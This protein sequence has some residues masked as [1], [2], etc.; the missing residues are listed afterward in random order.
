[1]IETERKSR[2]VIWD[3][4]ILGGIHEWWRNTTITL[5][6]IRFMVKAAWSAPDPVR[7]VHL[8]DYQTKNPLEPHVVSKKLYLTIQKTPRH[9]QSRI[10]LSTGHC[11]LSELRRIVRPALDD[12]ELSKNQ[13]LYPKFHI[14]CASLGM[15]SMHDATATMYGKYHGSE[16][17]IEWE[18]RTMRGV[19][20]IS[21]TMIHELKGSRVESVWGLNVPEKMRR[22]I[23]RWSRRPLEEIWAATRLRRILFAT[24]MVGIVVRIW[25]V[26]FNTST[27]AKV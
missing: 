25:W 8:S 11:D 19:P 21:S 4:L 22:R 2:G 20:C 16:V 18:T 24:R 1:M 9:S 3:C 23:D 17:N 6:R 12:Q 26:T 5:V 14:E 10:S 13:P 15:A 27:A 7:S